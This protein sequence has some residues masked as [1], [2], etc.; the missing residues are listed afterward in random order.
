MSELQI[1]CTIMRGGTS[2]GLFFL[3]SDLPSDPTVRTKM[4]LEAFGSPDPRQIDGLG[5]ADPLTSKLAI[6]APPARAGADVDYTFGQVSISEPF[7][8][9]SGN[10]G[11]ISSAVGP[12]ALDKGLAPMVEPL[13]RI[14]IRNTNTEKIILAEVPVCDGRVITEGTYR[15]AGVLG[16]GAE[17]RLHFLNPAGAATGKLLPTSRCI[18][19]IELENGR[20]VEV[21]IVDAGNPTAFVS[22]AEIGLQGDELPKQLEA[23]ADILE[24][25][26][27]IRA[28]V[29]ER[30]GL[31]ASWRETFRKYRTFP[32]IAFVALPSTFRTLYDEVIDKRDIDLLA[33][34]M[35]M[36]RPHKAFALT[37]AIPTAAASRISGSVVNRICETGSNKIRIGHPSGILEL[38]ISACLK[39]GETVIEE[40]VVGR[41]AR[42]LMEGIVFCPNR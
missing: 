16:T 33:R 20:Q 11:N 34:V 17:I 28:K 25:L 38:G 4:I 30:M 29:A 6:I 5:G 7:V 27:E 21:S 35:S 8:D 36:G 32:K 24:L 18:D 12:Y 40:I 37:A 15:I 23:R 19:N 31:V 9:F 10:C 2:K 39:Q 22:A 41:T 14:R 1:S 13:S 26:E 42:K 3:E